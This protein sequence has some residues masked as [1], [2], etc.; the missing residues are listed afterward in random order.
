L[1][2]EAVTR[3]ALDP[4]GEKL[5][6][7]GFL[8][9]VCRSQPAEALVCTPT[10]SARVCWADFGSVIDAAMKGAGNETR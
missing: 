9:D 8:C 6:N 5:E 4:T 10:G 2:G 7:G 3:S 1:P